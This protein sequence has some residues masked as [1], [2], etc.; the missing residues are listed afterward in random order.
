[1]CG[2]L[3]DSIIT[4]RRSF[5]GGWYGSRATTQYTSD[6]AYMSYEQ[7]P[8]AAEAATNTGR[9]VAPPTS[10]KLSVLPR[11]L[12]SS[13]FIVGLHSGISMT[14][15][16]ALAVDCGSQARPQPIR[17]RASGYDRSQS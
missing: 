4:S 9:R 2:F 12:C 15:W 16:G 10:S 8:G 11:L 17:D 3:N 1:M 7:K 6:N 13:C 5:R 14:S